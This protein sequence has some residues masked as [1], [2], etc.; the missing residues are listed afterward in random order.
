MQSQA[1]FPTSEFEASACLSGH[2][3]PYAPAS[4]HLP[5]HARTT[6]SII[7]TANAIFG[8]EGA[9]TKRDAWAGTFD[10]LVTQ[11]S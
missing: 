11:V 4:I 10:D 3:R 7:A 5:S 2:T 6:A 9:L 1:R 8:L